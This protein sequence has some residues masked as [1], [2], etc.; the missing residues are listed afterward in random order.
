LSAQP[1]YVK[2]EWQFQHDSVPRLILVLDGEL[3]VIDEEF[4][5]ALESQ[6]KNKVKRAYFYEPKPQYLILSLT[7]LLKHGNS[8]PALVLTL[9]PTLTE[10]DDS[11]K[12]V[13]K[14]F[15]LCTENELVYDA[16]RSTAEGYWEE[17]DNTLIFS[18]SSVNKEGE[19]FSFLKLLL[20][21]ITCCQL[22]AVENETQF[23]ELKMFWEN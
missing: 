1:R 20:D 6:T 9:S 7:N 15:G 8:N 18:E 10:N 5:Q 13:L 3:S 19:P 22:Y 14:I 17:T 4:I 11:A 12:A 2:I 16:V 23:H 21:I